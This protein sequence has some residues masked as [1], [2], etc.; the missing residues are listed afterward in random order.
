MGSGQKG[1]RLTRLAG[2]RWAAKVE[3]GAWRTMVLR[4]LSTLLGDYVVVVIVLIVITA[5]WHTQAQAE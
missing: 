1:D 2:D 3:D 4:I 5:L